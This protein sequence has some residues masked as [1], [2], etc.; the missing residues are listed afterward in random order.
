[1]NRGDFRN[2]IDWFGAVYIRVFLCLCARAVLRD[3]NKIEQKHS[4]FFFLQKQQ[5]P[6]G[7]CTNEYI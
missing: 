1:M 6:I 7:L 3:R 4:M 5:I 2:G